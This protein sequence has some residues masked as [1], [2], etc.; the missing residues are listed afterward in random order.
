MAKTP[1]TFAE[2]SLKDTSKQ[3]AK[4]V[5]IIRSVKDPD[6]G[7]VKFLDRMESIPADGDVGSH[8]SK[9]LKDED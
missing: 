1:K 8:V 9:L 3:I 2:K 4:R 7:N 5:R 6:T